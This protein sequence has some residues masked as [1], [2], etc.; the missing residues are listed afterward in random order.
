MARRRDIERLSEEIEELFSDLWQVPRFSGQ[1]RAF[2]PEVDCY[3]S[4][5]PPALTIV[6]ELAGIDP[7]DV[8]I[9][10]T[11]R[12]L[13]IHGVRRRPKEPGRVYQQMEI[14][15]GPLLRRVP[16][17]EEV[18]TARATAT[19]ERGLLKVVLPIAERPA[20]AAPVPIRVEAAP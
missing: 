3:R 5:D 6:A 15:Y 8:R 7:A 20:R 12:L 11:P 10:A 14:E 13:T 16:L 2:R 17:S 9:D 4:G 18:D 1:R 19:Y